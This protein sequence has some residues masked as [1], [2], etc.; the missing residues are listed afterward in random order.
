MNEG[1]E[2]DVV[3][4]LR[5]GT[6]ELAFTDDVHARIASAVQDT[7]ASDLASIHR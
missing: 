2:S 6:T 5:T 3:E 4:F 7:D 1:Q